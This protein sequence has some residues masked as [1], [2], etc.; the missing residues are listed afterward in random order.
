MWRVMP[1]TLVIILISNL[2]AWA[3]EYVAVEVTYQSGLVSSIAQLPS[4]REF[5]QVQLLAWE[6]VV[7]LV[8][9]GS[10]GNA[11]RYYLILYPKFVRGGRDA[12]AMYAQRASHQG[13]CPYAGCKVAAGL[14]LLQTKE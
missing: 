3:V 10:I 8:A 1:A 5:I 9:L 14:S 7:L 4:T 6:V 11:Y 13:G 2:G 12:I